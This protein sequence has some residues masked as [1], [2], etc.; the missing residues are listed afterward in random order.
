MLVLASCATTDEKKPDYTITF[1]AQATDMDPPKTMFPFDLNGRRMFFK[2]VPEFSQQNIIAYH[3]FPSTE[4]NSSGAVLQLDFRGK[5]QLEII[6]R[7][8]KDEYLLAMVNAKPVDFVVLDQPVLDGVLTLWQGLSDEVIKKM[9][10]R[11]QRMSKS[12]RAPSMSEDMDMRPTTVGDKKRSYDAAKKAEREA[13]S[14]KPSKEREVPSLNLP[15]APVSPR[16]PVEGAAPP[17]QPL[18]RSPAP[19]P[20]GA[21]LPLPKP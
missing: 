15:Q 4:G 14:G 21:D 9:D 6:T 11:V 7:T 18:P 1:H 10:K 8:R 16:L 3:P 20:P 12:G 19:L 2:V 17:L 5:S 13:A